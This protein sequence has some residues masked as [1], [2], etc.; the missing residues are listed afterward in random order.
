MRKPDFCITKYK[1]ADQLHG[2]RQVD[3]CLCFHY[4]DS[5]FP[6][7][8]KYRNFRPLAIFC[9]CKVRFES[10]LV[11]NPEDRFS[12]LDQ[13]LRSLFDLMLIIHRKH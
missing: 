5:A 1:G 3:Q 8:S 12:N 11:G 2:D 10:D 6:L 7:L 9:G 13:I 4:I